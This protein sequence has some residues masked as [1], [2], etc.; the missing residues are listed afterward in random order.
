MP[1]PND[2]QLTVTVAAGKGGTGK[3]LVATSL[4]VALA[5][6]GSQP[7][8]LLD[9]DVEEP[10][11]AILL[12]PEITEREDIE[13]L[14]PSVD[15]E[16]CTRCG[17]CAEVCEFSAIAVIREAV[18]TFPELC[19][20]CGACALA[21]PVGAISEVPKHVGVV[22]SGVTRHGI[23][24][25]QG[26]INVGEQRSGPVL[27]GV[28]RRARPDCI[29]ILD[30]PPGTAC[31]MQET[32]EDSDFCLLVTEPTPFGLSDLRVAVDTCRALD[33]PCGVVLNRDGVGDRGVEEYCAGPDGPPLL[34]RIPLERRV[35]EAYSRGD[36]LAEAF[37]DWNDPLTRLMDEVEQHVMAVG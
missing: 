20:A 22:S 3:T 31:P 23:H 2:K 14:I 25:C 18:L 16:A 36:T 26:A 6:R 15:L 35:A 5:K 27:R 7:V 28:K 34:L 33:V 8:G 32:V 19:A 11:A 12:K 13:V 17:R 1:R 9:C 30:A 37:D 4:A 24:F 21:C 10:N 29:S